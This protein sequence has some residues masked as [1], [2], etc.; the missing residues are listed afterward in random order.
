MILSQLEGDADHVL[1]GFRSDVPKPSGEQ[2]GQVVLSPLS[3]AAHA[4]LGVVQCSTGEAWLATL[5]WPDSIELSFPDTIHEEV[6]V[7]LIATRAL[8]GAGQVP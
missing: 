7:H 1:V 4:L 5:S 8:L 3:A 2:D 6:E